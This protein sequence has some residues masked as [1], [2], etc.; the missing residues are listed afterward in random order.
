MRAVLYIDKEA[1]TAV[2]DMPDPSPGPD[3]VVVS[4]DACGLCGS[5]VHSVQNGQCAPGQILG[6]E[7][8][9]RIVAVGANVTGWSEGQPV[10][11]SP[12]GSCGKCRICARGLAFRC[13]AAPN[14]GITAQG[15]YAQYVAVP[16]RQLVAL[17]PE[18]TI[19]LGS[20]AEPLSVGSQAV[21][22]SGAGPGDPVLVYGVGPIGLY[23]IMALRLAG[24]GPVVAAGRSA[25]RRQAAADVGADVVIDTREISVEEYAMQ[26]G[27]RFAAVLECSA[28][29]GAFAEGL[30]VL[31]PGGTCVEV[32][33]TPEVASLPLFG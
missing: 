2:S 13:P 3:D 10:A 29:P 24:A 12:L 14:I 20:H 30:A 11:A 27:T 18:L 31:E 28:A 23:S 7:F 1:G 16:A 25:G 6:H 9:G 26:A 15:A 19:E 32:A 4:V 8:S 22:L 17:P 5:D 21:K 33:L